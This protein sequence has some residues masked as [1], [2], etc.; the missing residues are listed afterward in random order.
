M[1]VVVISFFALT[2]FFTYAEGNPVL[3]EIEQELDSLL[4][5]LRT[6]ETNAEKSSAN[7]EFKQ[8]MTQ[9]LNEPG[10]LSYDF[11]LLETVGVID[12]PDEQ[13]RIV[14]WNV[15]QEDFSHTY[16]CFVLYNDNKKDEVRVTELVDM[17]FGMPS[18]PTEIIDHENWYGALYYKIIPVKRGSKTI[19][20]LLG[21]DHNSSL[22]QIKLIDA[23]YFTSSAVKFGS[24]IFK[25]GKETKKRVFFEHSKKTSMFLNYEAHRERIMMD[26]LSPES[27][28]L[29]NFRSYYVPDMSYDA[30][31]YEGKK[32]VLK[33]DVIGIN[34][35]MISSQK[36][37]VTVM[38]N[39]GQLEKRIV[40]TNWQNPE[41]ATAPAGGSE[42]VAVTPETEGSENPEIQ[43][44]DRQKELDARVDKKDKR[45]P[46]DLSILGD[47]KKKKRRWFKRKN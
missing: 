27:P 41:D 17:S 9:A 26:H 1:K 4:D 15:E 46:N 36:Q 24:P 45:N 25:M 44:T 22:S 30:F 18:Q 42:H 35:N 7:A 21:W 32:W 39:Q 16:H 37:E 38:N 29:K 10:A 31:E 33:E 6:A 8:L 47:K 28:A 12:S 23:M 3:Q 5:V 19:Y 34:D 2:S 11:T 14:N 13:V 43:K 20:T 40:K